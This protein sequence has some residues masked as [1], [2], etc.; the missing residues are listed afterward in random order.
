[1]P[2]ASAE[3][4]TVTGPLAVTNVP[5]PEAAGVMDPEMVQV[6]PLACEVKLTPVWSAPLMVTGELVG[7]N[8]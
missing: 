1:M 8:V 4:L 6:E 2:F 3:A 7:V 5:A